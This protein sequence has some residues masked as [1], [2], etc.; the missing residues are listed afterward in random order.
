M[1]KNDIGMEEFLAVLRAHPDLVSA[2]VGDP[3]RIQR[4]LK[5][6]AAR[7]LLIGVDT[8]PLLRYVG[9][10]QRWGPIALCLSRSKIF[11][12]QM[13]CFGRSKAPKPK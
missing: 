8:K 13:K 1:K 7:Q 11:S 4:L 3:A 5:S 9:G 2:L 6:K 10:S 12:P